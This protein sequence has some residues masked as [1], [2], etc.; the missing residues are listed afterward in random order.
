MM[1]SCTAWA[2]A[3][4]E[5]VGVKTWLSIVDGSTRTAPMGLGNTPIVKSRELNGG[6]CE[7][8]AILQCRSV[9]GTV[10]NA[11]RRERIYI[12]TRA[13]DHVRKGI[14]MVS[15]VWRKHSTIAVVFL[16]ICGIT[17]LGIRGAGL[18]IGN[19]IEKKSH[20]GRIPV[21]NPLDFPRFYRYCTLPLGTSESEIK[22][23]FGKPSLEADTGAIAFHRW[24]KGWE[25][26]GWSVPPR[27]KDHKV[28]IYEVENKYD[29]II[30]YYYVDRARRLTQVFISVT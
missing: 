5:V 24:A 30:V 12:P 16:L 15:P 28:L 9:P 7:L 10:S 22:K 26:A 23:R 20:C 18:L 14:S 21:T 29:K 27:V 2:H 4:C 17:F 19:W 3:Y 1:S 25:R 8:T 11:I 6:A 13:M